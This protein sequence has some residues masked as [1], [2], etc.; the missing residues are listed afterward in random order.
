MTNQERIKA[1]A[2]RLEGCSWKEI[3]KALGYSAA[4]VQQD[5][6]R[7]VGIGPRQVHCVYPAL[8]DYI[9]E[10]YGGSVQSFA[11]AC[12][13]AVSTMYAVLPGRVRPGKLIIDA[14]LETTGLSYEDA[15][16]RSDQFQQN[17]K[18]DGP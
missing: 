12:G 8:R 9:T 2:L 11:R 4:T 5:L 13:V 18:E 17:H 15:F 16:K 1:F 14:L 3:G 10:R 7:C 6:K